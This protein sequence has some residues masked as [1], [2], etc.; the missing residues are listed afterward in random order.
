MIPPTFND[1][2]YDPDFDN[3]DCDLNS[4]FQFKKLLNKNLCAL[5]IS[6]IYVLLPKSSR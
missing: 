3:L 6:L 1:P 5:V 2:T 4:R